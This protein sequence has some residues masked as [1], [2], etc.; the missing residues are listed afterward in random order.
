MVQTENGKMGKIAGRV[1]VRAQDMLYKYWCRC[2]YG[3]GQTGV[4]VMTN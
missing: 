2:S 1:S 4:T 3:S